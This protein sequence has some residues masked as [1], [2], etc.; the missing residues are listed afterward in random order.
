MNSLSVKHMDKI[1]L[2]IGLVT[3]G[4]VA[5]YILNELDKQKKEVLALRKEIVNLKSLL[6]YQVNNTRPLQSGSMLAAQ[7]GH[8]DQE[9]ADDD[10]VHSHLDDGDYSSEDEEDFTISESEATNKEKNVDTLKEGE[11]CDDDLEGSQSSL[12]MGDIRFGSGEY[13][14]DDQYE[15]GVVNF[16]DVI[17]SRISSMTAIIGMASLPSSSGGGGGGQQ[18][19]T[20]T[21]LPEGEG[22]QDP[23]PQPVEESN[24][25]NEP[26]TEHSEAESTDTDDGKEATCVY[27]WK[28]GK[29]KG[30]VCGEEK[31]KGSRYC[32]NHKYQMK[33]RR[34]RMEKKAIATDTDSIASG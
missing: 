16:E 12:E 29:R 23:Q 21:E 34:K 13:E 26:E 14:D 28:N 9:S 22:S 11:D 27:V 1:P 10:E 2:V 4:G 31:T 20:I 33:K 8:N 5:W 15:K 6:T 3:L 25:T 30:T 19:A 32:S 18:T 7:G 17:R 24:N